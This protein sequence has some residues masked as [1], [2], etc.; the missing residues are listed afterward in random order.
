MH[1]K[2]TTVTLATLLLGVSSITAAAQMAEPTTP[3][4][5]PR[6]DAQSSPNLVGIASQNGSQKVSSTP[7]NCRRLQSASRKSR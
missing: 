7:A 3:P 4:D 5:P 2:K 6:F 1:I